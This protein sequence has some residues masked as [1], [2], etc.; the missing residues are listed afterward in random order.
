MSKQTPQ[1]VLILN[2]FGELNDGM[3]NYFVVSVATFSFKY[4]I[5]KLK[6]WRLLVV[7]TTSESRA[8]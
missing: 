4:G 8:F 2:E 1:A 5:L 3:P 6:A 7:N